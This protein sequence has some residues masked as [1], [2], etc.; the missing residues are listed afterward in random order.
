M[1]EQCVVPGNIRTPLMEIEIPI[2]LHT[3]LKKLWV[4]S[5]P[6]LGI[7][8]DLLGGEG[9]GEV[10]IISGTSQCTLFFS[11]GIAVE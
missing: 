11:I 6:P 3:F 1:T 7:S 8:Y 5:T 9:G 2:F 10:W 4:L